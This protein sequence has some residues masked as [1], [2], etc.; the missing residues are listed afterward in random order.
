MDLRPCTNLRSLTFEF[1]F[2][3]DAI[4]I[5]NRFAWESVET[6]LRT[7][8]TA[9]PSTLQ[10]VTFSIHY[11]E[12]MDNPIRNKLIF[13]DAAAELSAVDGVLHE[14]AEGRTRQLG[15]ANSATP[16]SKV[17]I[18]RAGRY[19]EPLT[20]EARSLF[21]SAFPRLHEQKALEVV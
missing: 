20:D 10:L 3:G 5:P 4:H 8:G 11:V 6:M 9:P 21:A 15:G 14:L 12:W 18:R 16:G 1:E 7:F 17:V 13:R 2:F 19:G